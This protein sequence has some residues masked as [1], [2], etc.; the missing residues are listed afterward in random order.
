MVCTGFGDLVLEL[1]GG[2]DLEVLSVGSKDG[3]GS[4]LNLG[5]LGGLHLNVFLAYWGL[6]R[7]VAPASCCS[8]SNSSFSALTV[9]TSTA[10][11]L[12]LVRLFLKLKVTVHVLGN[13]VVS[14]LLPVIVL[15]RFGACSHL[16]SLPSRS[17]LMISRI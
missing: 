4:L 14:V 10:I 7:A 2:L 11:L 6:V 3:P 8:R 15:L 9:C 16:V 12:D 5:P 13:V 17:V 1:V